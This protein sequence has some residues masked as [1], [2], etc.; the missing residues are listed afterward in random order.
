MSKITSFA[1]ANLDAIR[2]D[3]EKALAA[4]EEKFGIQIGIGKIGY[5]AEQFS[6]KLTTLVKSEKTEAAGDSADPKW[7]ADFMRNYYVFGL[8]KE[9]LGTAIKHNGKSFKLVGSRCR[10]NKPLVLQEVGA[11]R[12]II[13]TVE[14]FKKAMA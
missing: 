12:F 7:I 5:S 11:E 13:F 14:A 3:M 2:A 6:C 8:K 4:V 1:P 10:A 9:D